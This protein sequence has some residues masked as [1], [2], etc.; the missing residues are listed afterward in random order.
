MTCAESAV[1]WR[2]ILAEFTVWI[3]PLRKRDM[4]RVRRLKGLIDLEEAA[5]APVIMQRYCKTRYGA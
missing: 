1:A 2:A 3:D 4:H 5:A